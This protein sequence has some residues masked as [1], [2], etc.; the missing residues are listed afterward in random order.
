M[1][2]ILWILAAAMLAACLPVGPTPTIRVETAVPEAPSLVPI[3]T[4]TEPPFFSSQELI[5][6][7][8]WTTAP[9][10]CPDGSQDSLVFGRDSTKKVDS[11]IIVD[12]RQGEY[13]NGAPILVGA[14]GTLMS[15]GKI[16]IE[17]ADKYP[18][19]RVFLDLYE[20]PLVLFEKP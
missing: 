2:I 6:G 16:R 10:N 14:C 9:I 15:L 17:D 20:Q 11:K 5:K 7:V 19:I 13:S 1:K 4:S 3:P 18:N 12:I 8:D